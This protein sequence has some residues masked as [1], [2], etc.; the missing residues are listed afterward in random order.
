[1]NSVMPISATEA[2]FFNAFRQGN[3]KSAFDAMYRLL[4][5]QQAKRR[6]DGGLAYKAE[7]QYRRDHR[8]R[9]NA[10]KVIKLLGKLT[11]DIRDPMAIA[12]LTAGGQVYIDN[13][14]PHGTMTCMKNGRRAVVLRPS[15][16]G[17]EDAHE[18]HAAICLV[19]CDALSIE[20]SYRVTDAIAAFCHAPSSM[21][22]DDQSTNEPTAAH[23]LPQKRE[24]ARWAFALCCTLDGWRTGATHLG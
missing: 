9:C 11:G 20:P 8:D 15:E 21:N 10:R 2:D 16:D 3:Y 23:L 24:R 22:L 17:A 18:L 1:M 12:K 19:L 5:L 7:L 14:A 13:F 6:R 4:N